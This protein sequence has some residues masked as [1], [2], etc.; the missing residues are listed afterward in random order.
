V[1]S[2]PPPSPEPTAEDIELCKGI[3]D[4]N[5]K[6]VHRLPILRALAFSLEDCG[7]EKVKASK[8]W[9]DIL[10]DLWTWFDIN[11]NGT[12]TPQMAF[13]PVADYL[14]PIMRGGEG[15][16]Y[17]PGP[18]GPH[19]GTE[20]EPRAAYKTAFGVAGPTTM[21]E[22]LATKAPPEERRKLELRKL[23]GG[24]SAIPPDPTAPGS[25]YWD[26]FPFDKKFELGVKKISY[27]MMAA[28]IESMLPAF[29]DATNK[30]LCKG[31]VMA[32]FGPTDAGF[33]W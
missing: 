24:V 7:I 12:V 31:K 29:M 11:T 3:V 15:F 13:G 25:T 20:E 5:T 6:R 21:A 33:D 16:M 9:S 18:A 28:S 1:A 30:G 10:I 32:P 2:P 27:E 17:P 19:G 23:H 14:W 26:Y 8:Q 4:V 22:C